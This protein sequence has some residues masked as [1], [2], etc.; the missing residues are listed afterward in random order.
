MTSSALLY[1]QVSSPQ[2]EDGLKLIDRLSP[3]EGSCVLDLGC[4]TG[5]LASVLAQRVGPEGKVTGVDPDRERI[6]L[7]QEQYGTISNLQ[8]LVGSDEEFPLGPYDFVYAN[9]VVHWIKDKESVFLKVFENTIVG[10]KFAIR[11]ADFDGRPF[12]QIASQLE[13]LLK[14]EKSRFKDYI[15]FCPPE[16]YETIAK[17]YG[18][19]IE[20]ESVKPEKIKFS[21]IEAYIEWLYA[22]TSGKLDYHSIDDNALDKFK[23]GFGD[24]PVFHE[25]NNI[26]YIFIKA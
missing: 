10:G 26:A 7:A 3:L 24:E 4:G 8:F 18:F 22:T 16:V 5:Y 13:E 19:R 1:R 2:T 6:R 14:P 12:G 9:Y 25:F 17:K 21:N 23:K 20:F 11:C 15:H